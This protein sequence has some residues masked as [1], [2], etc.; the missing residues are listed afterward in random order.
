[1][2]VGYPE[3]EEL[4]K[5]IKTTVSLLKTKIRYFTLLLVVPTKTER[6]K[7]DD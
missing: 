7:E 2:R 6:G 5:P 1:M 3:C 4:D